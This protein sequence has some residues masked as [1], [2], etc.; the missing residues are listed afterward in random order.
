MPQPQPLVTIAIPT[1]NRAGTYL[2]QALRSALAQDYPQLEIIVSDNASTDH[3]EELMKGFSDPRLR[4]VRH[5]KNIGGK[6]NWTFCVRQAHGVYFLLLH[7][8]DLI[9]P[10][11][12]SVCM[13]V[14]RG[15]SDLG[16]IRTG[17]RVIDGE[18]RVL[19]EHENRTVGLSLPDFFR[20][21]FRGDTAYYLANTL[22]NTRALQELD[23]FHSKA[24]MF[25]DVV[26][27]VKIAAKL[28]RAEALEVK[29]SFRRHDSN[30]GG[31]PTLAMD[32][33]EDCLY[34]RD[35]MVQ[36]SPEPER[37]SLREEATL[38]LCNTAY[39]HISHVPG[40]LDRWRAY[41]RVYRMFDRACVPPVL[42]PRVWLQAVRRRT[43]NLFGR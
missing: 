26:T 6:A 24:C 10:D 41:W 13:G 36:V 9:D 15:R 2:P 42:L 18:G 4:Y 32:W 31:N 37:P 5:E 12:V 14:A 16:L 21:W 17:I 28:D 19:S 1:Y 38:Y 35:L 27:S 11:F 20:A 39:R 7:D 43:R 3:T 33:A 23:G 29:A 22:Y 8:D 25:D 30:L 40:R 34:L